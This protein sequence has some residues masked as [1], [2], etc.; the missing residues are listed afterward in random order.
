MSDLKVRSGGPGT[1]SGLLSPS[2][3][4]LSKKGSQTQSQMQRSQIRQRSKLMSGSR[5]RMDDGDHDDEWLVAKDPIKPA[6]QLE[7]SEVELKQEF[8]RIINANNPNAPD[9]IIRFSFKDLEYKQLGTVD[10]CSFHFSLDGNMVHK[11]SDEARR[12]ISRQK[13]STKKKK[14]KTKS[15]GTGPDEG[16]EDTEPKAEE[17]QA[18]EEGAGEEGGEAEG[19]E[20]AEGDEEIEQKEE[21]E[22]EEEVDDGQAKPLRNQFNF[23]ERASQTFNYSMKERGTMT[24]PPPQYSYSANVTQFVIYEA[25]KA[26]LEKQAALKAKGGEAASSAPEQA[27]APEPDVERG[28]EEGSSWGA[29]AKV[30]S[31]AAVQKLERMVNQNTF[32][33]I[34]SDF[35]FYDDPSDDFKEGEGTV[36]PLWKFAFSKTKKMTVTAVVWNPRYPDMFAVGYGSYDFVNQAGGSVLVFSLKNPSHPEYHISTTSGVMCIDFHPEHSSFVAVGCYDGSVLVYDLAARSLAEPLYRST[37]RNGK[38]TDPVWQVAWQPDDLN[39]NHTFCSVASDGRV[40]QW[41]LVKKELVNVDVIVLSPKAAIG[42]AGEQEAAEGA[43]TPLSGTCFD[44]HKSADLLFVVGTEEGKMYKC[45]KAYSTKFLQAYAPH[46]M[47]VYAM[48]W[49]PHHP[50]IFATCGADWT[51]RIYDHDFPDPIFTFDLGDAVGDM[52]WA[53]FSATTFTAVTTNGN[54]FVFDLSKNK[55]EPLCQQQLVKTSKL[56]H[57][58]FGA[59]EPVILV[60]DGRGNVHCLKLSPNL[61]KAIKDKKLKDPE[62][63]KALMDKVLDSVREAPKA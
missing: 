15:T 46:S 36:L 61:R 62:A 51:L 27:K 32:D 14:K 45:S 40:T 4:Q 23:S 59:K 10:H 3:G 47:A 56:T 54:V 16:I 6:D 55:H 29:V 48:H 21:E 41:T 19:E 26:H 63:Q 13:M 53:P 25:Y 37:A 24:E 17:E 8:T 33:E 7:L 35:A 52:A 12:Q 44:F 18:G 39:Q 50:S 34:I 49:N 20:G 38:H 58:A 11:E 60:G 2:K 31:K 9:N 28:A 1:K 43:E 30:V 42:T 22:E 5:H 57:V